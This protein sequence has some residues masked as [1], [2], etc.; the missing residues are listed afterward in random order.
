MRGCKENE[1]QL[2]EQHRTFLRRHDI[3]D[4]AVLVALALKRSDWQTLLRVQNKAVALVASP[5]RRNHGLRLRLSS[6]HCMEC[7][8]LGIA[9]WK[10][11]Q[12]PAFVYVAASRALNCHKIGLSKAP[13]DRA[14][15]LVRDGYGGATDWIM[16]YR[17]KFE[18]AGQVE[19]QA[20]S[21][22]RQHRLSRSYTRLGHGTNVDTAELFS[23]DYA[24]ARD[25]IEVFS[26]QALTESWERPNAAQ[27]IGPVR[28]TV[29]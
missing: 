7:S 29:S 22:L 4:D 24:T 13:I 25:A 17:R 27:V 8:P 20:Q 12:Q 18:R 1:N 28:K 15:T 3:P 2:T 26:Q 23:C 16:L 14:D 19:A 6:G 21:T 5:C 10:R 11:H 9:S